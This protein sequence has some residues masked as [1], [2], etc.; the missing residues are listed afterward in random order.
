MTDFEIDLEWNGSDYAVDAEV[1]SNGDYIVLPATSDSP[2]DVEVH[3]DP[4]FIIT[5]VIDL[6]SGEVVLHPDSA[7]VAKAVEVLEEIWWDR[8]LNT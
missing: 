6:E 1:Y 3:K 8:E 2:W 5:E 4:E 7:L